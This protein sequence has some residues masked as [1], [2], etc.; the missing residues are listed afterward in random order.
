M[1][2][3]ADAIIAHNA[4][5]DKSWLKTLTSLSS[6]CDEKKWICT[7]ND[8]TWPISKGTA[9]HLIHIS[10]AMGVPVVSAHRA[11][12]DCKL[13]ADCFDKIDNLEERLIEAQVERY[14]YIGKVSYSDRQLA[15][16]AG[17]I[18]NE[19][20]ANNWAKKMTESQANV[21]NIFKIEKV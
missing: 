12:T 20:C 17:F 6:L 4:E 13:I 15:K 10:V 14:I 8:F 9:L 2:I 5:F 18:W 16:D 3:A 19:L 11:L 7:R 21:F 1:M